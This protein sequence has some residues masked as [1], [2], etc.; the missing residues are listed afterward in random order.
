MKSEVSPTARALRVLELLQA[1]PGITADQIAAQ[2]GVTGRAVRRYIAVLREAD[3]PVE[4]TRGPYGGY[5]LGRGLRL[6]PLIFSATE[7]LGL[8]MAVLDGRHAATD[9]ADPVGVALDKIIRA[10]PE[11]VGRQAATMRL[12]ATAVPAREA[13]RPDPATTSALVEAVAAQ[14]RV[15][16]S[17]RSESGN[18]WDEEADP[19]AVVV[20]HGYWYLLCHSLRANA[21]RTYR[22][23]RVQS[24]ARSDGEFR[25]PE[26]IDPADLLEQHLGVGWEFET[27]V[28]F[29]AP[30]EEVARYATAPMGRLESIDDGRRCALI[31]ATS[32]PAMYAGE[33]LAAIPIPF[34]VEGGTE[35]RDAVAAVAARLT[36]ALDAPH[37]PGGRLP[38]L[39][40]PIPDGAPPAVLGFIA[41]R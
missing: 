22:I 5:R 16:I 13:T 26:D 36:S 41:S 38:L 7:A 28:V 31:G 19:W 9:T 35:L 11:N 23:D 20:R 33:W 17:Y 1:Q 18:Q 4:S 37:H 25:A 15:R 3:I 24:V 27:K 30:R 32:N 10:L 6:P 12:H 34:R 21:V 2:L 29:D 39:D 8:V 14:R 40:H